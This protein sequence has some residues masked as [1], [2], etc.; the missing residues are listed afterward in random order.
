MGKKMTPTQRPGFILVG[1]T[2]ASCH[3]GALAVSVKHNRRGSERLACWFS[4][5]SRPTGQRVE[6]N[7]LHL[8]LHR[9][10]SMQPELTMDS[11][12]GH[13]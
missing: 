11:T 10:G 12:D 2:I 4:R 13:G 8:Q 6:V 7:P 1:K 5:S 9:L 3:L